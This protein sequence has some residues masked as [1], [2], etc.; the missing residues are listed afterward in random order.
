MRGSTGEHP[1]LLGPL[2]SAL[3]L[4]IGQGSTEALVVDAELIAELGAVTGL[5][6]GGQEGDD[7]VLETRLVV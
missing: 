5:G 6:G 2:D 3:M 7:V 1:T 4:E